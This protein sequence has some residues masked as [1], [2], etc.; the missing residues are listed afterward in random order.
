MLM[1]LFPFDKIRPEQDILLKEIGSALENRKNLIIHAPTGLGKTAAALAPCL[2]FA[3]K[4]QLSVFFLTSR[5]TQ[6]AIA[7]ETLKE[8]QKKHN[9]KFNVTDLVGK[10]NMCLQDGVF[11]LRTNEFH[12]YCR[13]LREEERCGFYSNT[14]KGVKNTEE[15]DKVIKE[16]KDLCPVHTETINEECKKCSL[17]PYEIAAS[18]AKESSVII[19]D[20]SYIFNSTVSSALFNKIQKVLNNCIVVIDEAHNL[21]K[22]VA[23]SATE[24]LSMFILKRAVQECNKYS[25][26]D[27][28][29]KLTSLMDALNSL[30]VN[31]ERLVAKQEFIDLVNEIDDYNKLINEL[32][33]V[34][35]DIREKQKQ[36]FVGSIAEFLE[37]WNGE[38]VGFVRVLKKKDKNLSLNYKCLDASLITKD[39][40]ANT[41]CTIAMSGT[42]TPT[43]MYKDL[44]GFDNVIEKEFGSP[45]PKENKL[46]LIVPYTTTKYT[47]RNEEQFKRI[48]DSVASITNTVPGNSLVLFPSYAIRD[49]VFKYFSEN[50][51]KTAFLEIADM[52]K[53]E[54]IEMLEK[55]KGYSKTGAVLLGA[56]SGNF[57]E[58]ID[59]MG[60]LLKCVVIVGLP[61]TQPDIETQEAIKYFDS[62]FGKGWDYGY[63]F[64]AFNKVLQ[65]AGRCIRSEKDRGVIVFL[66]E[67]YAWPNYIRCFPED[68]NLKIKKD[69]LEEIKG[70]FE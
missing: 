67:R 58:G 36:S 29:V 7:V 56:S 5:H 33:G 31:N 53:Q 13:K 12:D 45:F 54:K 26:T 27:T 46:S 19:C 49:N 43:Y 66:D 39:I 11:E 25:Y 14:R 35:E 59:L 20:Y 50:C 34:A 15:A 40:I 2:E 16:I 42:L 41:Y 44:L 1:G 6:H 52:S 21:P 10:K 32:T 68:M 3:L 17:C 38:D 64:P 55:F 18:L 57:A 23:D 62:K 8:V 48:S 51:D 47:S 37:A 70:F 22:R 63:L 28:A 65:G 60:D 61:L 30:E 4:K 9:V 69:Y 24:R